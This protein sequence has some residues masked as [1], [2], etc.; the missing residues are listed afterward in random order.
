MLPEPEI[1]IIWRIHVKTNQ[2]FRFHKWYSRISLWRIFAFPRKAINNLSLDLGRLV[3]LTFS[4]FKAAA[5]A[6]LN[7]GLPYTFLVLLDTFLI[8]QKLSWVLGQTFKNFK[9]LFFF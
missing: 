3:F 7:F 4:F 8:I 6:N 9:I 2:W 5:Y 1:T